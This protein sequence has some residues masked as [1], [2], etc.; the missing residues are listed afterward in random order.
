MK[1]LEAHCRA[2]HGREMTEQERE[3]IVRTAGAFNTSTDDEV[4]LLLFT[5]NLA[6]E[7]IHLAYEDIHWTRK[8][9]ENTIDTFKSDVNLFISWARNAEMYYDRFATRVEQTHD[10]L[11]S[12]EHFLKLQLLAL[13]FLTVLN[14]FGL[15]LFVR[16][17]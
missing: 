14:A 5:L 1:R 11:S 6:H 4:L 15:F 3:W 16:N 12:A 8:D 2:L 13:G 9:F 17:H 10:L 7:D